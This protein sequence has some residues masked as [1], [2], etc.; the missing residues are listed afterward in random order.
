MTT[1]KELDRY[2]PTDDSIDDI[3]FDILL[4]GLVIQGRMEVEG[5]RIPHLETLDFPRSDPWSKLMMRA[6][7]NRRES[8][9]FRG[10][11]ITELGVGDGRNLR[12]V[13]V[14][15]SGAVGVDIEKWRLRV[16]GVNLVTG[17]HPLAVETEF[18]LGDAVAF[19]KRYREAGK[20]T[21]SG[22]VL[23]CLPQ[24]PVGLNFAD[25]YDGSLLL[26][27]YRTDWEKSGLT[28]NAAV[29]DN[30]RPL[31]D[32]DLRTLII[33]SDRVPEETKVELFARTGW[34]VEQEVRV[35]EPIQ[36]D[37]DT[38][39]GWVTQI[40]DGRRFYEEVGQGT[41]HPI[42]AIE[43][44]RRRLESMESGLG[45][46]DLNVYHGLTVYQLQPK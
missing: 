5:V 42:S 12:A 17:A 24:S 35:G 46:K 28:L 40:D 32:N 30:L 1:S 7:L 8:G 18:W 34:E 3:T 37:P 29:L 19:L 43:A 31:A 26:D 27:P 20:Q 36:Q 23:A 9:V 13:G 2:I 45:R 14:G 10:K 38:G 15:I 39:I 16:A 33:L 44:E 6:I 41:Y 21:V 11:E 25:K 4:K 22:W